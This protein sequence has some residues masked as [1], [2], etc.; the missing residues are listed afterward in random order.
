M[1]FVWRHEKRGEKGVWE[2][3]QQDRERRERGRRKRPAGTHGEGREE[4]KGTSGPFIAGQAGQGLEELLTESQHYLPT[5][6]TVSF[7]FAIFQL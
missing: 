4:G 3:G 6:R 5:G 1:E 2:M 7:R